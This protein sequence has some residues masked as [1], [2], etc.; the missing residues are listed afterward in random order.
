MGITRYWIT[1][2]GGLGPLVLRFLLWCGLW[3]ARCVF[4]ERR[5]CWQRGMLMFLLK[6]HHFD[7]CLSEYLVQSWMVFNAAQAIALETR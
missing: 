4:D 7:Y 3:G 2:F 1:G 5:R 6:S